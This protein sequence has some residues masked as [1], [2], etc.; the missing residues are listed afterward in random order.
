MEDIRNSNQIYGLNAKNGSV[1]KI[2][3]LENNS[4]IVWEDIT[5]DKGE[6]LYISDFGNNENVRNDLCIYKINKKSLVIPANKISF[7][8][9]K[10]K[11]L[12]REKDYAVL[13]NVLNTK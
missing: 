13:F 3:T 8:H 10:Q 4:N 9:P 6:N 5:K 11:E 2:I 12:P 1:E 7:S